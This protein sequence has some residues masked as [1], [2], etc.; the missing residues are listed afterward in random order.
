MPR[1]RT[2]RA[3]LPAT[4]ASMSCHVPMPCHRFAGPI[5]PDDCRDRFL[6]PRHFGTALIPSFP[7][8]YCPLP[9]RHSL[10]NIRQTPFRRGLVL[11]PPPSFTQ[12]SRHRK[13]AKNLC[14]W[15]ENT[16]KSPTATAYTMILLVALLGGSLSLSGCQLTMTK[17]PSLNNALVYGTLFHEPDEMGFNALPRAM[18]HQ[19]GTGRLPHLLR[20]QIHRH[21]PAHDDARRRGV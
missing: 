8:E 16:M 14:S 2:T 17:E 7:T 15:G 18:H 13:A 12:R 3:N 19:H 21:L 11:L 20:K 10:V 9:I 1:G 6:P 4:S 5:K